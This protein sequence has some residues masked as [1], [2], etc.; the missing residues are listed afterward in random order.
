M[1]KKHLSSLTVLLFYLAV[2]CEAADIHVNN[3]GGDDLHDG[4]APQSNTLEHGPVRSIQRALEIAH[5]G[6]R[7]IVANTGEP[8]RESVTIQGGRNSGLFRRP[9][10]ILG[11]GAVLD[12]SVAIHR[13]V[14]KPVVVDVYRFTPE[15]KNIL[16]YLNGRPAKR[17]A[18]DDSGKRPALA[19]LEWCLFDGD[20]FFRCE[21]NRLPEDYELSQTGRGVG[22]TIYEARNV[23][24][25]NLVVQGFRL[26]GINAH[27]GA[28]NVELA[29]LICQGNGRSGISIGGASRLILTACLVGNNGRAQVRTEGHCRARLINCDLIDEDPLA[30]G[31]VK[32]GGEVKI[33]NSQPPAQP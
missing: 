15:R 22:I 12:G 13:D 11:N 17:I 24:V 28:L 4:L 23:I 18:S 27:D 8:Y 30:P 16:I 9:F 20:V 31:L 19:P 3:I 5:K 14:W 10:T 29:G 21:D 2:T 1:L 6:D 33:E 26:D 25:D 32:E 7:I